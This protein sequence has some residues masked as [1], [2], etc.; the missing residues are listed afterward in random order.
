M[1]AIAPAPPSLPESKGEKKPAAAKE[2]KKRQGPPAPKIPGGSREARRTA[3]TILE[4]LAGVRTPTQAAETA[5]VSLPRYYVLEERAMRGMVSACEARALGRVKTPEREME[6]LRKEVN[7]LTHERDRNQALAR[8]AQ[9]TIGLAPPKPSPKTVG[10][11]GRRRKPTVRALR[12]VEALAQETAQ[13]EPPSAPALRS[14]EGG[15]GS[16]ARG[17]PPPVSESAVPPAD[18]V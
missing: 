16:L 14:P 3:A 11:K 6:D 9:R 18:G 15:G 8:V 7:R 10:K 13:G 17:G 1:K 2:R 12:V 4:V 5:G